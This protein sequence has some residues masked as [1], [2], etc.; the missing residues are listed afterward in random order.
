LWVLC[1]SKLNITVEQAVCIDSTV[2]E[3][4]WRWIW[5]ILACYV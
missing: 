3:L 5:C 2:F 1:T 4:G